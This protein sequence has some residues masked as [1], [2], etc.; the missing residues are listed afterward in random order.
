MKTWRKRAIGPGYREY[1]ET[2]SV[3][4]TMGD[5]FERNDLV[6]EVGDPFRN[7]YRV[8]W[9]AHVI[10]YGRTHQLYGGGVAMQVGTARLEREVNPNHFRPYADEW[11]HADRTVHAARCRGQHSARRRVAAWE[12]SAMRREAQKVVEGVNLIRTWTKMARGEYQRRGRFNEERFRHL[13]RRY[14]LSPDALVEQLRK[15]CEEG[16]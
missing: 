15:A 16:A 14:N 11:D 1:S 12:A 3:T 5:A 4:S 9:V 10:E 6:R 13:A 7:V 8:L 2:E